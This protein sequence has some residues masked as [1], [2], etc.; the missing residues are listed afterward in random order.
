MLWRSSGPSSLQW[1]P[2]QRPPLRSSRGG[3]A[4]GVVDGEVEVDVDLEDV[5]FVPFDKEKPGKK[6][7]F[8]DSFNPVKDIKDMT[9]VRKAQAETPT[10]AKAERSSMSIDADLLTG[11]GML[12]DAPNKK[13]ELSLGLG[14]KTASGKKPRREKRWLAGKGNTKRRKLEENQNLIDWLKNNDVWVSD[15][16]D[17]GLSPSA[18]SVAVETREVAENEDSGRGVI[19]SREI[20][21]YEE[22][23]RVPYELVMCKETA[24]T[25]FGAKFI[26]DDCSEYRA[27]ALQLI[28]ERFKDQEDSFWWPYIAVLPQTYQEIGAA[29]LWSDEEL[30]TMMEGSPMVNQSKQFKFQ[31]VTEWKQL[32]ENLFEKYSDQFPLEIY[33]LEN[34]FWAYAIMFSR[35]VRLD[36]GEKRKETEDDLAQVIALVPYIDLINHQPQAR[37]YIAGITEGVDMALGLSE[38]E[39]FVVLSSDRFY[40]KYEQIYVS[41][42]QKSNAYLL[43]LYGF[44]L[45]RNNVDHVEVTTTDFLDNDPL[46]QMKKDILDKRSME[47][48]VFELYRDRFASDLMRFLR[49][50]VVTK[51]DLMLPEGATDED[52]FKALSSLNLESAYEEISERRALTSLQGLCNRILNGYPTTLEDDEKLIE[53]RG[54]FELLPKN[55]RM[56]VRVRY[57]E[58]V[59]FRST[60]GAIDRLLNNVAQLTWMKEE[61]ERKAK[62]DKNTLL[63]QLG[64]KWNPVFKANSLQELAQELDILEAGLF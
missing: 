51:E 8:G 26:P 5:I 32:K 22:I 60:I 55:Q 21:L 19:A 23:V 1:W 31:I 14:E 46:G 12:A 49:L 24:R 18:V 59:I 6:D 57:Q 25:K 10:V 15:K 33:T 43:M 13:E 28:Y 62:K 61:E 48:N 2:T 16:S 56:A 34:W 45:E 41:Y 30:D 9:K 40:E 44:C 17:W 38:K 63:G 29:A 39:R 11:L 7:A 52:T 54:M 27:I 64:W 50:V 37:T 4:R 36:Y 47:R 53:D 42:G 58:K 3:V 35:A 20:Q